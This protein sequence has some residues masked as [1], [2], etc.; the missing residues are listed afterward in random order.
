MV[1]T[2]FS[3]IKAKLKRIM[4]CDGG[5]Y[6]QERKKNHQSIKISAVQI[7]TLKKGVIFL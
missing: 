1:V 2:L 6:F 5:F 7:K 4:K 3:L